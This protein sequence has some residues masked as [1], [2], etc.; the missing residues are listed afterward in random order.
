MYRVLECR[1][2]W[3]ESARCS[4]YR[5]VRKA[6]SRWSRWGPTQLRH[7]RPSDSLV[8][9]VPGKVAGNS[10][11]CRCIRRN[12]HRALTS[13]IYAIFPLLN[14]IRRCLPFDRI[15][16]IGV[17]SNLFSISSCRVPCKSQADFNRAACSIF[18]PVTESRWL[19]RARARLHT[20]RRKINGF[21]GL[22]FLCFAFCY[23][24]GNRQRSRLLACALES[25][26]SPADGYS[27][28]KLT[29]EWQRAWEEAPQRTSFP[30]FEALAA[31]REAGNVRIYGAFLK[32]NSVGGSK[33]RTSGGKLRRPSPI[34][35]E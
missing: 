17:R 19:S 3:S 34:R 13:L 33:S 16:M 32:E 20:D 15:P 22:S 11:V 31:D 12:R 21:I 14:I 5:E 4:C 27:M 18:I 28:A 24:L 10:A 6:H 25:D 8:N 29:R 26:I 9:R 35:S 2:S 23:D 30:R 1:T 7:H